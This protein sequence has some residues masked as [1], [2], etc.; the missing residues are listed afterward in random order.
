MCALENVKN[1]QCLPVVLFKKFF[2]TEISGIFVDF[3][4]TITSYGT[5]IKG[6]KISRSSYTFPLYSFV[7]LALEISWK[8]AF[9]TKI[10]IPHPIKAFRKCLFSSASVQ[11]TRY[12]WN[13]Q[14]F[15][16]WSHVSCL[17]FKD[18]GCGFYHSSSPKL[19]N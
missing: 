4:D 6:W 2:P 13:G 19:S 3:G 18:L 5:L 12:I 7:K 9:L 1:L 11:C 17:Q 16:L 10:H 8:S 14:Y 15:L